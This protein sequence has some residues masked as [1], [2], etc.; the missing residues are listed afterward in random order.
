MLKEKTR[1]KLLN[2]SDI[3]LYSYSEV[4]AISKGLLKLGGGMDSVF[5]HL[6][7]TTRIA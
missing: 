3:F 6:I 5:F 1:D 4:L 7:A 2:S